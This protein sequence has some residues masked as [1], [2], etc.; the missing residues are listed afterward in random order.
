MTAEQ[1]ID[2]EVQL[3]KFEHAADGKL[4]SWFGFPCSTTDVIAF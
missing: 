3:E 2:R 1:F 4:I